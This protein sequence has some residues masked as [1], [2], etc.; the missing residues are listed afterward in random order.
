MLGWALTFLVV[1]LMA[2]VLGFGGI[3]GA[4]AGIAKLLFVV[5]LVLFVVSM[6]MRAVQGKSVV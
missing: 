2:A 4:S 6:I 5:F 1:A 3:A